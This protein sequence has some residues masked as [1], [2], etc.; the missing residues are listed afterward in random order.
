MVKI[1][2][3]QYKITQ[4]TIGYDLPADFEK[5]RKVT[6]GKYTLPDNK[7]SI[8]SRFDTLKT[9]PREVSVL[10]FPFPIE[11]PSEVNLPTLN[12]TYYAK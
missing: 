7:Y 10:K 2:S 6:I 1:K 9:N 4:H 5:I 3:K 11:L 8:E 12:V